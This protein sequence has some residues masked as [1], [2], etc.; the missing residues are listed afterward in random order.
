MLDAR[1]VDDRYQCHMAPK[2]DVFVDEDQGKLPTLHWPPKPHKIPY[3]S[4]LIAY[5]R[6]CT[7]TELVIPLTS[8]LTANKTHVIQYCEKV[9]ESNGKNLFLSIKNSSESLNKLKYKGFFSI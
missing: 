1:S 8:C 6:S 3:K 9:Y 5:S 4:R 7:I 2:F